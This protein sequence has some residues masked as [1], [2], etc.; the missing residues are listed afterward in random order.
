MRA[1]ESAAALR[2]TGVNADLY[3]SRRWALAAI[4]VH[5]PIARAQFAQFA[6][7]AAGR[8][9][10]RL[11]QRQ[12]AWYN[13]ALL[14]AGNNDVSGAESSLRSAI[15]CAPKWFK[16]HWALARVLFASGRLNEARAEA[17]L[18]LNLN[19]GKDSE[20][21]STLTAILRSQKRGM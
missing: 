16:P 4:Q 17:T 15:L 10:E 21:T 19:A 20:V 1:L 13:M 11:E 18:A 7:N 9:T 3:F 8:G 2:S 6:R 5:D 12:N 14:A